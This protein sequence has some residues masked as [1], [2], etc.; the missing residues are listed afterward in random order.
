MTVSPQ[1]A[2]RIVQEETAKFLDD[3]F[4]E[5]DLSSCPN[6]QPQPSE[7]NAHDDRF[8]KSWEDSPFARSASALKQFVEN[9]DDEAISRVA[10]EVGDRNLRA[11]IRERKQEAVAAEFCR[12]RPQY[13][14][15]DHNFRSL[16]GC[17]DWN[18]FHRE[19]RDT[20]TAIRCVIRCGRMDV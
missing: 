6:L 4:A 9:P 3:G 1:Q 12:L 19:D 13:A 17:L 15:S 5:L 20:D 11:E 2:A 16:V 10:D 8:A 7:S 18:F 14:K